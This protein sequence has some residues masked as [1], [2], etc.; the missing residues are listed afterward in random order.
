MLKKDFRGLGRE[1][2]PSPY[3]ETSH[4]GVPSSGGI[5]APSSEGIRASCMNTEPTKLLLPLFS[6]PQIQIPPSHWTGCFFPSL[7]A[8]LPSSGAGPRVWSLLSA[9]VS[10]SLPALHRL[11]SF[12]GNK[13]RM[14]LPGGQGHYCWLGL[15]GGGGR[16]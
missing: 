9:P 4:L 8:V 14:A 10:P 15:G 16:G 6:S 12:Y 13:P 1:K 5:R 2:S 11:P 3:Q 7:S